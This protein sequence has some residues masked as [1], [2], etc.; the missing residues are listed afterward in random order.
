M[1]N[2]NTVINFFR[3]YWILL[4]IIAL[5]FVLQFVL[6]NPYY[7][8]H[9]DEFLHLD[10]AAHPAWGYISVPP[11]TS[12]FSKLIFLL[13]GNEFWVR[14][15][16]ALFGALTILFIWLIVE[17]AG[18]GI[19]SKVTASL[20]MLFSVFVRLNVL[21]QPNAFDYLAWTVIFYLILNYIR[22]GN[23]KWVW[24]VAMA[25]ALGFYNKYSVAFLIFGLICGLLLTSERRIFLKPFFWAACL[26]ALIL[27]TPNLIWQY[28]NHFPVIDHMRVLKENQLDN[29]SVVGFLA[30]QVKLI[31]GSIPLV[32]V[33]FFALFFYRPF[34]PYRFVSWSFLV[35]MLLFTLLKAKDYYSLGLYPVMIA[36][37]S[38]FVENALK[39][40]IRN[41]VIFAV[42]LFNLV[43]FTAMI[44]YVMPVFDPV[45]ITGKKAIFEKLGML[46]WEDGKNHHLPQ[47]FADMTG[48]KEMAEKAYCAYKMIPVD[49][50]QNTLVFC[51]NYGETGALNYFNRGKMKEAFSFNTDYIYWLPKMSHIQNIILVGEKPDDE[52]VKLFREVE[53][54]GV[55][56][57][58]YARERNTGIYILKDADPSFTG[59]FYR[60]VEERKR[61]LDIF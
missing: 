41:A 28:K 34:R 14:F 54:T 15:F 21:Y 19:F 60:I 55:V 27:V 50:Q 45:Q 30:G 8:L 7:E 32:I 3:H 31:F 61:N 2:R 59:V 12:I 42:I 53:L 29:N 13:G 38:V 33:A 39:H 11:L 6:V 43:I 46:R 1:P 24:F 37:G 5:K 10:Q 26:L 49:E 22:T 47:D 35:V 52:V 44:Q 57:N 18:G 25:I 4:A 56:E 20:A 9:R 23:Q 36:F 51:D 16:P 48:W 40:R 17:S 58:E